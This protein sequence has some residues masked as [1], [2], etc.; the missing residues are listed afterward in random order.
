M[1]KLQPTERRINSMSDT[2]YSFDV[3]LERY[4]RIINDALAVSFTG[5]DTAVDITMEAALYSLT[6][7]GKRI[8][9]VLMMAVS[10]MLSLPAE[11]VMPFACAVEMIHTY[12]LIHDDLPC[13]DNDDTRRGRPT[14]HV[15]YSEPIALLAGDALLNRAY[16]VML[17]ACSDGDPR[18][19]KA[20]AFLAKMAGAR[21]MIGGQTLDILSEG[22]K[23]SLEQLIA[24][25]MKKTGCL[26][27]APVIIPVYLSSSIDEPSYAEEVLTEFAGHI[28]LG[29][30]I[31]DDVLD[32]VSTK[33]VL[34]KSIGK[35][36]AEEKSTFVTLYGL[37]KAQ[38]LLQNEMDGARNVLIKLR[39][40]GFNT[41]FLE[42]LSN[43]L[44][45]RKN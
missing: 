11:S 3:Q 12:S 5:E 19:A 45:V 16:E 15:R 4:Q 30:Q 28:G 32:V 21:G 20:A 22:K 35:D 27:K 34:G 6:A 33:E 13:M 39:N 14:C 2:M 7:G 9:P 43:Y 41:R 31:K 25:Q 37:E 40:K 26:L 1:K 29:F 42:D 17:E 8:R 18:K 23:I 38:E 24:L 10:D 44:L 36:A